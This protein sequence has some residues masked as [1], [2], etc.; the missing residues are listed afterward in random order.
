MWTQGAAV[1]RLALLA[2]I[3]MVGFSAACQSG[4][5]GNGEKPQPVTFASDV[6]PVAAAEPGE[7]LA[8]PVQ[9]SSSEAAKGFHVRFSYLGN[10]VCVPA[11]HC[12]GGKA[13]VMVPPIADATALGVE[14]AIV[15]MDGNVQDV[16]PQT[17]EVGAWATSEAFTAD[18]FDQAIGSGLSRFVELGVESVD[19]LEQEGQIN[20]ASATLIRDALNQQVAILNTVDIYNDNLNS[21]QLAL[22]EQLL[23]NSG[24][25]QF[26]ADAGGV[27]LGT[28]GSQTSALHSVTASLIESALI[29]ADFA[30][31]L[32]GEVRGCLNLL[33][34]VMNQISGWPIIGNWAQ[35]VANWATGLSAQLQPA[36]DF[37]NTMV[38]SDLVQLTTLSPSYSISVGQSLPARA[39]GRYETEGPFNQ[40]LFTTTISTY[41][42]QAATWVTGQMSQSQVLSP[43]T[44]Y[45]Q[46]VASMVPGWITNWLTQNGYISA[47]VVPGQNF[48][49]FAIPN[50]EL[51]MAQYRFDIAGIVANLLNLPYSAVNAFFSWIGVGAG[52]PVGGFDGVGMSNTSVA[53]YTPSSDMM[54]GLARGTTTA[55]FTAVVCQPASGWWAQWGFYAVRSTKKNVTLNVQ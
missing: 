28:T 31:L 6:L 32:I 51:D 3:V 2:A 7:M 38:P 47:S 1:K 39:K 36:Q 33:A 49:V 45:V 9:G 43:Y 29:K 25:L 35:G 23:D 14:V 44:G 8:L 16:H 46:Q 26:L 4:D 22:L 17:L 15:D 11:F 34:Y 24:I 13:Y 42:S 20:S 21:S 40:Q 41:V 53:K 48:T 50:F 52:A 30:S 5:D 27:T 12:D 37:I 10:S 18:S 54:T 19:A 55:T